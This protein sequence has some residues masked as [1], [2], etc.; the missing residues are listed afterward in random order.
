MGN[1]DSD[2]YETADYRIKAKKV[3][4]GSI[5]L[6]VNL[7]YLDANN[8]KYSETR[9]VELKVVSAKALGVDG[10]GGTGK[11]I[12]VIVLIVAGFYFY[13]KWEKKKLSKKK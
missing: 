7:D 8:N 10:S 6:K 9:D 1:I 2:D 5:T 4:D 12:F 13:R 3:S 11:L